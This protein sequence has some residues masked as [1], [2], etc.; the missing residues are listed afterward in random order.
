LIQNGGSIGADGGLVYLTAQAAA[1]LAT[2]VINYTGVIEARTLEAGKNGQIMLMGGISD[3]NI[4][5]NN[6]IVA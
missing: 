5:A 3:G 1:D 2:T 4:V 6:S